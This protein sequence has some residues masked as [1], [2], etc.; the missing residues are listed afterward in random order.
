MCGKC[1]LCLEKDEEAPV[2]KYHGIQWGVRHRWKCVCW[3]RDCDSTHCDFEPHTAEISAEITSPFEHQSAILPLLSYQWSVFNERMTHCHCCYQNV[4]RSMFS[5]ASEILH[6]LNTSRAT[7]FCTSQIGSYTH[8]H[9][10]IEIGVSCL[11][12][13]VCQYS[14]EPGNH[15]TP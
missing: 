14:E 6:H 7:K 1:E 4:R 8:T 10:H 12:L 11:L 9:T 5:R 13:G 15:T 3:R 2:R